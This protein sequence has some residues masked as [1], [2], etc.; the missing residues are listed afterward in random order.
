MFFI[1]VMYYTHQR[2][3]QNMLRYEINNESSFWHEPWKPIITGHRVYNLI[4]RKSNILYSLL[5]LDFGYLVL[6]EMEFVN[7]ITFYMKEN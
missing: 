3:N 1:H 7:I 2:D 6:Y 4:Y 5:V